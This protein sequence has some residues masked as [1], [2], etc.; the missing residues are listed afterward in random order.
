MCPM[1]GAAITRGQLKDRKAVFLGTWKS[2][3][4]T[5]AVCDQFL[6]E[7]PL[8]HKAKLAAGSGLLF[9]ANGFR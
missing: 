2:P 7:S 3:M 8:D 4:L 1:R 5:A 6:G 9:L